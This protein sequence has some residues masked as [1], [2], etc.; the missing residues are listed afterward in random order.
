MVIRKIDF[1]SFYRKKIGAHHEKAE[2]Y[3]Q[4]LWQKGYN[5]QYCESHLR[6]GLFSIPHL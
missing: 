3:P 2:L 5:Q 1:C 6:Y 4:N